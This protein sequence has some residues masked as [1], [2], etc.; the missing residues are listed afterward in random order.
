[1]SENCFFFLLTLCNVWG[2]IP[3]LTMFGEA[4]EQYT[5]NTLP[6]RDPSGLSIYLHLE[7]ENMQKS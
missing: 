7:E 1:M 6:Y 4:L 5:S 3:K 2:V